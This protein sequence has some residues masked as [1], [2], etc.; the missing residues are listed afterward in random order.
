[1]LQKESDVLGRSAIRGFFLR[2]CLARNPPADARARFFFHR[3][4]P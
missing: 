2:G 3:Y 4:F 1:M